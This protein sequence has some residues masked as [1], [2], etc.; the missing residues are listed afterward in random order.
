MQP[1]LG[2]EHAWCIIAAL[3]CASPA[4][5][6]VLKL[7]EINLSP[8]Q[9]RGI[10]FATGITPSGDLLSFVAKNSG[11]WQLYRVRNWHT[12]SASTEVLSVSGFFSKAETQDAEGRRVEMLDAQVFATADGAYAVCVANPFWVKRV[13]GR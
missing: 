3:I 8:K 9:D 7:R 5:A 13:L 6:Q 2:W 1:I 11:T 4:T 10:V 12:A